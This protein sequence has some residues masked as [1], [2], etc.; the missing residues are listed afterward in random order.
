[1]QKAFAKAKSVIEKEGKTPTFYVRALVG[2]EDFITQ[3]NQK[4]GRVS[5]FEI[6]EGILVKKPL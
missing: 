3:V 2:M 1:M 4:Y 6:V 5:L